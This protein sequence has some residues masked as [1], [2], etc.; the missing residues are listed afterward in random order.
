MRRL[1]PFFFLA[2]ACGSSAATRRAQALYDS[3]DYSGAARSAD[4][5]L[6]SDP[7]DA[8][9]HRVQLRARLASGDAKSAVDG[10]ATWRGGQGDDLE[11]LRG[12]AETTLQQALRSPSNA[13]KV[14]A[15][16][17]IE[18]L[19]IEAL[20]DDVIQR[21]G[22][23]DDQVQA[24]ASVAVLRA[25]PQAP[26][27]LASMLTSEDPIARAIAVRG[28]AEKVGEHGAD[29]LRTATGDPDPRVR[30]AAVG[31]LAEIDD[32]PTTDVLVKLAGK[33]ADEGVRAAATRAL[34]HGSRGDQRALAGLAIGDKSLAVRL[35][36]VELL[37]ASHDDGAIRALLNHG[38]L[39]VQIHAAH[40]VAKSDPAGAA[41]AIDRALADAAPETRAAALNLAEGAVG[42]PGAGDR[43]ARALTDASVT[44][45][46]AAAR[47]LGAVGRKADAIGALAGLLAAPS[48]DDRIE[49]AADLAQ[50]GDDRGATALSDLARS[51]DTVPRRRAA[52][53]A[54]LTARG[55]TPGLVAA[56]ADAAPEVRVD[57]ASAL[58][59]LVRSRD[60][61]IKHAD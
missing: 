19:E 42:K 26:Q 13:I 10:Y 31:G 54:H 53:T 25:H 49:A 22:D 12:L 57:A 27:I 44:V 11:A 41:A 48:V 40:A 17:S 59:S 34:A 38:D 28:I 58:W 7:G 37:V 36:G 55:I 51:G 60:L 47:V 52:V 33:D 35:A 14:Q 29:D 30:M 21:L 61:A 8:G 32:A 45:R 15:I 46:L 56:L 9:L 20:A 4:A 6:A 43:A 2:A 3:G 18:R 39:L 23:Q 16:E 24:A 1:V 5:D 50:L